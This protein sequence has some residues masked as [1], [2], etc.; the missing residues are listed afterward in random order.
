MEN[1]PIQKVSLYPT[2]THV[3][4]HWKGDWTYQRFVI[5]SNHCSV[6]LQSHYFLILLQSR[7]VVV[8]QILNDLKAGILEN[9]ILFKTSTLS[10]VP[11]LNSSYFDLFLLLY[12]ITKRMY[13][14]RNK[15]SLQRA[16]NIA[17]NY[18][19]KKHIQGI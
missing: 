2:N 6:L 9:E 17:E 3:V 7:H 4:L 8:I 1:Q 12:L 10:A 11:V 15:F 16:N 19:S 5:A 13:G 14:E 18:S